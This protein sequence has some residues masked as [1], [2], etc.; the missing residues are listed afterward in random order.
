[1]D[2]EFDLDE[3]IES[4]Q[5]IDVYVRNIRTTEMGK[6]ISYPKRKLTLSNIAIW[7]KKRTT[8]RTDHDQSCQCLRDGVIASYGGVD[9]Y[10][11]RTQLE[12]GY[13]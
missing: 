7:S 13:G 1:M 9:I 5:K 10:I 12:D 11:H 3:A 8:I 2:E 4:K 6:E